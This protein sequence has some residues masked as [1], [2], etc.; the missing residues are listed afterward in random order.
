MLGSVD[1]TKKPIEGYFKIE[2]FDKSGNLLDS[3]ES[4][5]LI[6]IDSKKVMRNAMRG[7]LANPEPAINTNIH[8][9]TFVLGT[10]GHQNDNLLAP[11][12]FQNDRTD[13]FCVE[14]QNGKAYPI[15]FG[16]NGNIIDEGYDEDLPNSRNEASTVTI[17]N[18]SD[19]GNEIIEYIFEIPSA[20]ANDS[21]NPIAYTEAALY[22][23]LNQVIPNIGSN[24][25]DPLVIQDYG[26]IFAMRTFPAK[27]K[28][29]TTSFKISWRIIF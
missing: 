23:N 26:D 19:S 16:A 18:L 11:K 21:G 1:H 15:T 14:N 9:N 3:W 13:L 25:G 6:M 5:N 8:I 27:I 24:P 29:S 12:N 17:N 4:S 22:T 20:N 7:L 10:D 28:D 2:Q